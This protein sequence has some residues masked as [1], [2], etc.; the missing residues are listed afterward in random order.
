MAGTAHPPSPEGGLRR[1]G[2][3][4]VLLRHERSSAI[5]SDIDAAT[6][7]PW[8][9]FYEGSDQACAHGRD[10]V[11][12]VAFRPQGRIRGV[13]NRRV[14]QA[15]RAAQGNEVV[16]G[17]SRPA[18]RPGIRKPRCTVWRDGGSLAIRVPRSARARL[19]A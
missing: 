4:F 12:D 13:D 17:E 11:W 14:R 6:G 9:A 16:R 3:A 7:T 2:R 8:K 19:P 5:L 15:S 10:R 18:R 1:T